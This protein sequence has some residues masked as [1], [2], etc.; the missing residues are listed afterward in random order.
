MAETF[1]YDPVGNLAATTDF[2]GKT[3]TYTYDVLNRLHQKIP[4]PLNRL[5]TVTDNRM[6]AQGRGF[7][8]R[9]SRQL[10]PADFDFG[11]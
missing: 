3:T 2:N 1:S 7:E 11:N 6:A 8:C 4:D 5:L 9:R 10:F